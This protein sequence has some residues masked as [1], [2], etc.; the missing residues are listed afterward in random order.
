MIGFQSDL[1]KNRI[2]A[3]SLNKVFNQGLFSKVVWF[4]SVPQWH[5]EFGPSCV[6][7]QDSPGTWCLLPIRHCPFVPRQMYLWDAEASRVPRCGATGRVTSEAAGRASSRQRALHVPG[8]SHH[9]GPKVHGASQY[10]PEH[11][12]DQTRSRSA[13]LVCHW[14]R[15]FTLQKTSRTLELSRSVTMTSSCSLTS[16]IRTRTSRRNCFTCTPGWT[17]TWTLNSFWRPT[18]TTFTRLNLL[19][20]E[21]KTKEPSRLYWGF[22]SGRGRVK[23]AGKWKESAWEL[24]DY[25]LP[26][27]LGGGYVLSVD[28]VHY[29]RLN[30]G[31]LKTW[32]SEDVSLGAW[33]APVDVKRVHDPRFDT[34]YK[35]RGC[36]N[37]YLVTHK[38]SLE[39]ML[40]KHQTLQRDGRL[41][42]EEVKLRLSYIY[43]WSVPPSQ[44][45]QRKDGIPW[46]F[47]TH[48]HMHFFHLLFIYLLSV[49]CVEPK[50]HFLTF[51][52]GF[53]N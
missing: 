7:S 30:V 52:K 37:K 46:L 4:P 42:K 24:C 1:H 33:L 25:Y 21:L 13:L 17:K 36:S 8:R 6:S 23:T 32:Q 47:D 48:D 35:S 11:L 34:E 18:T 41:C 22:F 14:H 29:V 50:Q 45:C 16:G 10:H 51:W 44:C 38:Q 49:S 3:D 26:Y 15:G 27:A 9:H 5:H 39:D 31:F 12:A 20:E 19:K 40:E 53:L 28:L 2:W 43:D